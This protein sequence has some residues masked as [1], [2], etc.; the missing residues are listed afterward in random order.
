MPG[1]QVAVAVSQYG[2]AT[3]RGSQV[4]INFTWQRIAGDPQRS[5]AVTAFISQP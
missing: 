5:Y 4:N 3:N 2:P 1:I